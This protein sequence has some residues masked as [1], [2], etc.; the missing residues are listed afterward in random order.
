MKIVLFI[1]MITS[2]LLSQEM[3]TAEDAIRLGLKNNYAIKIARNEA[4]IS[5]NNKGLGT[6]GFLPTL[7]ATASKTLIDSKEKSNVPNSF[8][9]TET[10]Q[11]FAQVAL[12]WTIFDGFSMFA[13]NSR[14]KALARLGEAQARLNIENTVVAILTAYFNVVQQQQL[15]DTA[16]ENLELSRQ[17]LEREKVRRDLG[18]V[19]STDFLRSQVAFNT[20][21]AAQYQVELN[22]QTAKNRLNTLLA[23]KPDENIRVSNEIAIPE[24]MRSNS[25]WKNLALERNAALRTARES[26]EAAESNVTLNSSGFY[27]RISLNGAFGYTD[28]TSTAG[29][30]DF[31]TESEDLSI[32]LNLS[33]NLFDGFRDNIARQNAILEERNSR[34]ALRDVE[35]QVRAAMNERLI[36]FDNRLKLLELEEQNVAAARQSFEV[37]K[38]KYEIGSSTSLDFRDAQISLNRAQTSYI[39][40]QYQARIALL[41]IEQLAGVI[42]IE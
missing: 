31:T 15:F 22:L 41:Q 23:Q 4:E 21:Q 16:S 29:A 35:L 6:A 36:N 28:R 30:M 39:V 37:Q 11:L 14:F 9:D 12:T 8:G 38:E 17:R 1:L 32:G 10:D 24:V 19:S 7:D 5:M 2:S 18:G 33:M 20:D 27:P 26:L 3:L 34:F 40:A 42:D 13:A 25:E